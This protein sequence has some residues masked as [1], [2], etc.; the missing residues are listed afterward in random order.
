MG[1][2]SKAIDQVGAPKLEGL[3]EKLNRTKADYIQ[4]FEALNLPTYARYIE[5]LAEFL[6]RDAVRDEGMNTPTL[7]FQLI[8]RSAD[9]Q[10]HTMLDVSDDQ[11]STETKRL[12]DEQD[13]D[14]YDILVSEFLPNKYGGQM[15]IDETNRV[16]VYFGE[17]KE[18]DYSTGEK[19][20]EYH[21]GNSDP[22]G[23]FKYSFDD[24]GLREAAWRVIDATATESDAGSFA[25][26]HH[27]G[28]Y[29]F[30]LCG[31]DLRPIFLD[32]RPY[33]ADS[34]YQLPE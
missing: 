12:I 21:V 3:A 17:G 19:T 5:P 18:A 30:A 28:Y 1:E 20:P 14:K 32:Y 25:K 22:T 16:E 6:T 33:S 13:I 2:W 9:M 7:W 15:V 11:I 24:V 23:T 4:E 29:E 27:P 10:K 31:D 34:P 26:A 8:P